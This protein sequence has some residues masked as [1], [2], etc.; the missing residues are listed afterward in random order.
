MPSG[1]GE[2]KITADEIENLVDLSPGNI[3]AIDVYRAF[4]LRKPKQVLSVL[5]TELFA[6][7]LLL[8]FVAPVSFIVLRNSGNLPE[9]TTGVIRLFAIVLG[10]CLLGI[11]IWN[12][13]LWKQA[14]Q[15]KSLAKLLD[16]VDKYNGVI[17]AITLMDELESVGNS[18]TQLYCLRTREEVVEA[19]KV[20]QKSLLG[21]LRVERMIRKHE[22]FIE[23]RYELL[24]NLENNLTTLMSF[25][26]SD[27]ASEYSRLLNESLQIG[28]SVHKEMRKLQNR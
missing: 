23:R 17:Q 28:M 25:D 12:I 10:V 3:L 7:G 11:L 5:L 14:K 16:E 21:G 1:L 6:F 24:A 20:T 19:L 2:L 26:V 18:T 15:M 9:E 27:R 22:G 4:I 8:I 13:Y